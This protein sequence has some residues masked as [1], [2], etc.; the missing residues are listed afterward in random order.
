MEDHLSCAIRLLRIPFMHYDLTNTPAS[1]QHFM[2]DVFANLLVVYVV[3]YLGGILIYSECL[4]AHT[5]HV[6]KPLR[7][8][9][10]NNLY[11]KIDKC[12]FGVENNLIGFII[13]PDGLGV[14]VRVSRGR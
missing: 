8:P 13:S 14:R 2:S 7:R 1:F 5:V 3:V 12:E 11:A 6:L 9:R 4:A 10:A